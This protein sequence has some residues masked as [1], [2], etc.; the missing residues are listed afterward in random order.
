MSLFADYY[1]ERIKGIVLE[2]SWGFAILQEIRDGQKPLSLVVAE[3]FI[4]KKIRGKGH[5]RAMSD[6][7]IR[8]AKE[9]DFPIIQAQVD[10]NT[11]GAGH[12]LGAIL[13]TGLMP[14]KAEDNKILLAMDVELE[15]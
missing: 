10:L 1:R 9:N 7:I 15:A 12:A 8:Y 4:A 5:F 11:A 13:G 2:K 6:E 14:V 3:I